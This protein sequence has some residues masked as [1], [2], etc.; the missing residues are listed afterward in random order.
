MYISWLKFSAIAATKVFF[1]GR[2]FQNLAGNRKSRLPIEK[3]SYRSKKF[4]KF[5]FE[6]Q[7]KV[8]M[9]SR[10]AFNKFVRLA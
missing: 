7:K 3:C 5:E 9:S 2:I 6:I 4:G 10:A 8:K 1:L